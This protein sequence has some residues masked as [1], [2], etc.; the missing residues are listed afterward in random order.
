MKKFAKF[1]AFIAWPIVVFLCVLWWKSG[2]TEKGDTKMLDTTSINDAHRT[3]RR[4]HH[5]LMMEDSAYATLYRENQALK[6]EIKIL[7]GKEVQSHAQS[8]ASDSQ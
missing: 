8:G 5:E 4:V 3:Y 2:H 6:E 1:L 7:K